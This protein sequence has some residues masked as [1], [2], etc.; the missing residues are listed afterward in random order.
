MTE[1]NSEAVVVVETAAAAPV[2]TPVMTTTDQRNFAGSNGEQFISP[3]I[4]ET[5][6]QTRNFAQLLQLKIWELEGV[7]SQR[8]C[9]EEP[10]P[11]QE[12]P[13]IEK[14]EVKKCMPPQHQHNPKQRFPFPRLSKISLAEQQEYL[15][16]FQKYSHFNPVQPM[17]NDLAEIKKLQELQVK[18]DAEREDFLIYLEYVAYH[19]VSDYKYMHPDASRYIEEL[20]EFKASLVNHYPQ[21]YS[22]YETIPL[23]V[24]SAKAAPV[25][26]YL[27][28]L[29]EIGSTRRVNL[30][31]L[32]SF[33]Q[34]PKAIIKYSQLAGR[35]PIKRKPT[36]QKNP[37]W[38][39]PVCSDDQNAER[40]AI[41]YDAQIV[42]S[43]STLKCLVDN[44]SSMKDNHNWEIPVV[45]KTYDVYIEGKTVKKKVV[46]LDKP[47]YYDE[48]T[49]KRKNTKF[50]KKSAR[51]FMT[52]TTPASKT[53][54]NKGK[55]PP[56]KA[57][58]KSS[59]NQQ[60]TLIKFEKATT[61]R[62][63]DFDSVEATPV[64]SPAPAAADIVKVRDETEAKSAAIFAI[65][66]E[67]IDNLETFGN[68][69]DKTIE[70]SKSKYLHHREVDVIGLDER[71]VGKLENVD[72]AVD[73]RDDAWLDEMKEMG[74]KQT[75]GGRKKI[76]AAV[77]NTPSAVKEGIR[78]TRRSMQMKN[79]VDEGKRITTRQSRKVDEQVEEGPVA[80]VASVNIEGGG[81]RKRG[82]PRKS[83][84]LLAVKKEVLQVNTEDVPETAA[85]KNVNLDDLEEAK[86]EVIEDSIES[87]KTGS[88]K[89]RRL[90]GPAGNSETELGGAEM[91]VDGGECRMTRARKSLADEKDVQ[92]TRSGRRLP[93]L[94]SGTSPS[95]TTMV[96]TR[97]GK[98][99]I[100]DENIVET[101]ANKPKIT[102]K[103][104]DGDDESEEKRQEKEAHSV[105]K[106]EN[107]GDDDKIEEKRLEEEANS[108]RNEDIGD[109]DD[110]EDESEEKTQEEEANS[111]QKEEDLIE[112]ITGKEQKGAESV[113]EELP[114]IEE[115]PNEMSQEAVVA[116]QDVSEQK[117]V[118]NREEPAM[119]TTESENASKHN[120]I[121]LKE[122]KITKKKDTKSLMS[123]LF[124]DDDESEDEVG[125]EIVA[126]VDDAAAI[127]RRRISPSRRKVVTASTSAPSETIP[128]PV[129]KKAK[130]NK[131]SFNI[132]EALGAVKQP[133]PAGKREEMKKTEG[134][135][136]DDIMNMQT[137]FLKSNTPKTKPHQTGSGAR[138]ED[139]SQFLDTDQFN[140]TYG[141]WSFGEHRLIVRCQLHGCLHDSNNTLNV[142]VYIIPK[143][144]Y[145]PMFGMEVLSVGDVARTWMSSFIRQNCQIIRPRVN[146]FNH[147][148][149]TVEQVD[150]AR[151]IPP[152][153][154]FK[155]DKYMNVI[156]H[157]LESVSRLSEGYYL[158]K[159]DKGD[160]NC[161]LLAHSTH[162][163][164]RNTYD[165]HKNIST[166][167]NKLSEKYVEWLPIDVNFVTCY[168][169]KFNRVPATFDPEGF[170]THGK[171][172]FHSYQPQQ[173]Q[174]VGKNKKKK[175][176]K[177]NKKK[178]N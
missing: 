121:P 165:F 2:A 45:V 177:K 90:K 18:I 27:G 151:I 24:C 86:D 124:G 62:Y 92:R 46:Y 58:F 157:I 112:Q 141:L 8:L 133:L 164:S 54:N 95:A 107:V 84:V 89:K 79:D 143:M 10:T 31:N 146:A 127:P 13:N 148:I 98:R 96:K 153:S 106:R 111:L 137:Q 69:D 36:D 88:D 61:Y 6:S 63:K 128:D 109:G 108:V 35:F 68:I 81:K 17:K 166:S 138:K 76:V 160:I 139:P 159:H 163:Q 173:Q 66:G 7:S 56:M 22:Y 132:S 38:N 162:E 175:N 53:G 142:P 26:S 40:L 129:V 3:G 119:K 42:V 178:S 47:F 145:Q 140:V 150:P 80:G 1:M 105:E 97:G 67:D 114:E 37:K 93:L 32:R 110:D 16:L 29:L 52:Q 49:A 144:E 152:Q 101:D 9:E 23:G 118:E 74:A 39:K 71:S 91:K 171:S 172:G 135:T 116:N 14:K 50:F 83:D 167:A 65:S 104:I 123:N 55:S 117:S 130:K 120:D 21:L 103:D 34:R 158:L 113:V 28:T 64:S 154:N 48:L 25:M 59:V 100:E 43:S 51:Y 155:P 147:D 125:M 20:L 102:K 168:H 122:V 176:K 60:T 99:S 41:K 85:H 131:S 19:S 15:H 44:H 57:G 30:P 94:P 77:E 156:H 82:R 169:R 5:F 149:M 11:H 72:E 75:G 73:S 4:F 170:T 87:K 115:T 12:Q 33:T 161:R 134:S 136:F 78:V 70:L 174:Q 126:N